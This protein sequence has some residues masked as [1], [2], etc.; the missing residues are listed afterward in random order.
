MNFTYKAYGR[1]LKELKCHGYE[2]ASYHN[3]ENKKRPVIL[4]HDIDND[5]KKGLRLADFERNGGVLST[6]F[7]LLTSDLYNCFSK[8]SRELLQSISDM[9]HEIGVHYDEMA[10]PDAVSGYEKIVCNIRTEAESLE[11][12]IGKKVTTVSMH[13]PSRGILESDIQIPGMVNSYSRVFFKEFKY[14][15]DSRRRWREPVEEIIESEKYDKLHILTHAFWYEQSE[16]DL[17]NTMLVFINQGSLY[18]YDII[19]DN[20]TGLEDVISSSEILV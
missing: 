9:G 13:R 7:V 5:L 17:H 8:A 3:W 4:R 11:N 6:F 12:I 1:L 16:K 2:Y 20:F 10:Y 15:S 18:R 14:L 19:S